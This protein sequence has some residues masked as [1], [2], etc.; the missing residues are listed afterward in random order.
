M[1]A[2]LFKVELFKLGRG[3]RR[4]RRM[5]MPPNGCHCGFLERGGKGWLEW[6]KVKGD[7]GGGGP[8]TPFRRTALLTFNERYVEKNPESSS[9]YH[10]GQYAVRRKREGI[11]RALPITGKT[12]DQGRNKGRS[13]VISPKIRREGL[14]GLR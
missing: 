11:P 3:V 5:V 8:K 10:L 13:D 9:N 2:N 4:K 12:L 14:D 1:K 6:Q 7:R